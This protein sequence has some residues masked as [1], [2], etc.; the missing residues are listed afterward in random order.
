MLLQPAARAV[1]RERRLGAARW[2]AALG[3]GLRGRRRAGPG[4]CG[5]R[6]TEGAGRGRPAPYW[7][8]GRGYSP[9][10]QG[11]FSPFA[12]SGLL[13]GLFLGS[14]LS[15][16]F[17][18]GDGSYS[19]GYQDGSATRATAPVTAGDGGG[20]GGGRW[21]DGGGYD[22]AGG[23][24][25]G[26]G[27]DGGGDSAARASAAATSAVGGRLRRRQSFGGGD[28]PAQPRQ[29]LVWSWRAASATE[30]LIDG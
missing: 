21:R 1:G 12:T 18:G 22:S 19:D 28:C 6:R 7:Q 14:L 5:T 16:G 29:T 13:P 17:G 4:R 23:D 26:G 8:G 9:Y 24:Y 3:A 27:Y 15:G 10:A 30:P 11:Y 20:D 2:R 25:G